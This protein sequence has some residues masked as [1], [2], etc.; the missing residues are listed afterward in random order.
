MPH[1]E[2][3]PPKKNVAENSGVPKPN[4]GLGQ[5]VSILLKEG[6]LKNKQIAYA[7]RIQ[8]KLETPRI[9]LD[10]LK[11]L[12]YLTDDQITGAI[13]RNFTS[14]RIGDLLVELGHINELQLKTCL[15]AQKKEATK[16]KL[17]EV[18]VSHNFIREKD[19][20]EILSVQLG[21]PL[22]EV[23]F[24]DID[25]K[26]ISNARTRLFREFMFLPIRREGDRILIA[27]AD[28]S[29]TRAINEAKR[30]F[31]CDI[32]PAITRKESID[33]YV[34]RFQAGAGS[35]TSVSKSDISVTERVNSIILEAISIGASDIHMEP[36]T[37][38]LRVRFRLDGVLIHHKDFPLEIVPPL[39]SRIKIMCEADIAEKRRHQGG[40]I[41][42]QSSGE[43]VDIRVS[44]YVTVH[45]EKIVMRLLRR[46][47]HLLS[48]QDIGMPPRM[49]D[50]YRDEA[51]DCPSGVVLVTGPT[52][53]GKTTTVYSCINYLNKPDVSII[54]AE[55]P[56]EYMVDGIAQ[57]SI[58][59]KINL[60]FKE[61]LRHIVRQDPDIVVIGEIRDTFSAQI[62]VQAAL[63]GH[64]VLT[65][66]HTEDS[67]GGLVRLMN[68]E[69]DVFLISST[70]LCVLA[71]RLLRRV[72][73]TCKKPHKMTPAEL[74]LLGYSPKDILN[75]NFQK[76]FGC[77]ECAYT[78]YRGR[79]AVHEMLVLNEPVRDAILE[80]K[81]SYQ[82][83]N[84][85]IESTG[86][87]TLMET[88]IA[89]AATG[90][91]TIEE[92]LRCLP[93]LQ[94]PRPLTIVQNLLGLQV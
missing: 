20:L 27:F 12:Q 5:I 87:V 89:I 36:L 42:F 77:N 11:D 84:I 93:R 29:D 35:V 47:A 62:A 70:V 33:K 55:E 10:I 79:L 72:C 26:L 25:Q 51:L 86:L 83:R 52:G 9:L 94:K 16:R 80:K 30:L 82:I 76:G 22:V 63:T 88:G 69:V 24:A 71:Q 61:T 18:L 37:D 85:S 90:A 53:S 78:G 19:L 67:I 48:I 17:G 54:T 46:Q 6:H 59:P 2:N 58:D 8:S 66:F 28:P 57:C 4:R 14:F 60:T 73:P 75:A 74:R 34:N 43:E 23:E 31:Q 50:R 65:T 91:T 21:F 1:S 44:F 64:K 40:R 15:E 13:R 49:L 3:R 39:T 41:E 56:V 81:T 45:G 38:R 92:V 32:N 7:L 68:M